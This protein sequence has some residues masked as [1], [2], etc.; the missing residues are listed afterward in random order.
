MVPNI[1]VSH[2]PERE[3]GVDVWELANVPRCGSLPFHRQGA[4][5]SE[6]RPRGHS[7]MTLF[8]T[9][10][11]LF[12]QFFDYDDNNWKLMCN[13]YTL[14]SERLG[15]EVKIIASAKHFA[16]STKRR[17]GCPLETEQRRSGTGIQDLGTLP[18]LV[19]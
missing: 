12:Q 14:Y 1:R 10:T 13:I 19:Y 9:S 18:M 8:P 15:A 7:S 16:L 2:A 17:P 6:M 3:R 11:R 4:Q 5:C